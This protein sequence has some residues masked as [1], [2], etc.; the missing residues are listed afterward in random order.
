MGRSRE[1]LTFGH[2]H[3]PNQPVALPP[4]GYAPSGANTMPNFLLHVEWYQR[5][6]KA[7]IS[8][9]GDAIWECTLPHTAAGTF[10]QSTPGASLNQKCRLGRLVHEVV[11]EDV[12]HPICR[13]PHPKEDPKTSPAGGL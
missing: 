1:C 9:G 12:G 4:R 11:D 2:D 3:G 10:C 13:L 6:H 5:I 8:H 7:P